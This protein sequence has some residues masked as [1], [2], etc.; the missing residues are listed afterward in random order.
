MT[1]FKGGRKSGTGA[2]TGLGRS[3]GGLIRYLQQGHRDHPDLAR[4]ADRTFITQESIVTRS[5]RRFARFDIRWSAHF[6][7]KVVK[8]R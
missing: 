8:E 4:V 6:G 3:F 7:Q 5:F 1:T 2:R